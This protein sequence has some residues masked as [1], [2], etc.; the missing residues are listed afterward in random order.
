V[1]VAGLLA[2]VVTRNLRCSW[3]Q[4][5]DEAKEKEKAEAAAKKQKED[6]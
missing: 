6:W 2:L 3:W 5:V 1:T 4:A